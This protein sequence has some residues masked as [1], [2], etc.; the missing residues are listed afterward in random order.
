MKENDIEIGQW[1]DYG[2]RIIE[3]TSITPEFLIGKEVVYDTYE[4]I[5]YGEAVVVDMKD[6]KQEV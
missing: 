4:P 6:L 3:I 5:H 1:I 2:E